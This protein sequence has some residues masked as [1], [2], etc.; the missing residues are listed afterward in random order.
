MKCPSCQETDRQIKD[1]FT[2]AGS[3][4]YRC[5]HCECRY[6]PEPKEQGYSEEVRLQA[7]RLYLEG[8]S[9]RGIERVLGVSY[10]SVGN[11]VR[12]Y[13]AQLPSAPLPD[14][15]LDVAEMDELYTFI[16]DKKT[17]GTS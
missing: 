10:Q 12:A 11:W 14:G 13:A 3:Q 16:G 9:Q 4:R 15:E 17:N 7:I 2:N 8:I 1:G 5:K 6:T